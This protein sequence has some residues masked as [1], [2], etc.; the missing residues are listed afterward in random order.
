[1]DR[2]VP[3]GIGYHP[4]DGKAVQE[5]GEAVGASNWDCGV[6]FGSD[7]LFGLV[8][9]RFETAFVL[10]RKDPGRMHHF[11]ASGDDARE[12]QAFFAVVS[13]SRDTGATRNDESGSGRGAKF[14]NKRW[15]SLQVR[16]EKLQR[17]S[18]R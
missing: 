8:L 11:C 14:R 13:S 16:G 9:P 7:R 17:N 10:G 4:G 2:L 12:R 6:R 15:L 18:R 1:M 5:Q 3:L